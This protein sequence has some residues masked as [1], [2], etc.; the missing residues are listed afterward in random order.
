[1]NALPPRPKLGKRE[2][3]LAVGLAFG[4]AQGI[5]AGHGY[6]LSDGALMVLLGALVT[7]IGGETY[8]PTGVSK[9]SGDA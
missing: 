8:R 5:L 2:R 4:T 7:F 1:M 9:G 6:G 3:W